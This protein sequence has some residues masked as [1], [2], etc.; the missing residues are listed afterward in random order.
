MDLDPNILNPNVAVTVRCPAC[1]EVVLY[2]REQCP[3]CGINLDKQK[4]R[5]S[6]IN[7]LKLD[8]AIS[9]ANTI[10]TFDPGAAL[11]LIVSVIVSLI[12]PV[13]RETDLPVRVDFYFTY[14][15]LGA[16][17][18]VC[19]WFQLHGRLQS[20]EP[21]YLSAKKAVKKSFLLWLAVNVVNLTLMIAG[22]YLFK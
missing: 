21:D 7:T 11:F 22:K 20:Q 9:S 5:A 10:R 19:F 13:L 18:V 8:R 1:D 12:N 14:V 4:L 15:C 3:Y 17:G 16:L 6:A 2:E